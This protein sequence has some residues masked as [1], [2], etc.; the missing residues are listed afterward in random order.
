MVAKIHP[1]YLSANP[2][3]QTTALYS[4]LSCHSELFDQKDIIS[5]AF[6]GRHGQAF[7]IDQVINV[8]I[9]DQEERMLMTG[10]HTV[11]DISCSVCCGKIGWV[12]IKSPEKNQKYKENKFIIEKLR[13]I[14]EAV[15]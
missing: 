10:L 8:S 7:L 14:K 15:L 2:N 4:C 5:R 3:Q 9:G 13:V 1:N 12:Y 6:Q 11:A